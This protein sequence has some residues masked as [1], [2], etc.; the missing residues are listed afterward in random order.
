MTR[1]FHSDSTNPIHLLSSQR[2][3]NQTSACACWQV[4]PRDGIVGVMAKHRL[5]AGALG[6]HPI[7]QG[8]FTHR[9]HAAP[10]RSVGQRYNF[11]G[12][13]L[14]ATQLMGVQ[15]TCADGGCKKGCKQRNKNHELRLRTYT[16]TANLA[17]CSRS[18]ATGVYSLVI[19]HRIDEYRHNPKPLLMWTTSTAGTPAGPSNHLVRSH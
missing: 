13:C 9:H 16:L 7:P 3:R 18:T 15:P 5:T 12:G 11:W 8:F 1:S 14:E 17:S 2:K 4:G 19:T 6:D 10:V